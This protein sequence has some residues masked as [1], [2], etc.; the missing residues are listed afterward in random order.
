M[1]CAGGGR[2]LIIAL[3]LLAIQG[4]IGA[5]DTLYYHEWKARLPARGE[6][7]ATE[8]KLHAARDF[9]YA[10]IFGSLP[11][12]AWRGTWALVFLAVLIIEII[13]TMWDFIAEIAVRKPI[14]DVYAGERVTHAVMGIVYG[15]MLGYLIP[16]LIRWWNQPTELAYSPPDA[17]AALRFSLLVMAAGVLLSGIRDLYAALGLPGGSWPWKPIPDSRLPSPGS[18]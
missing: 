16:V 9:F 12:L 11:L 18:Q 8:L 14:G 10:I 15:A 7:S 1:H 5:F 13:L 2:D 3:W 17:P 6:Q 4:V